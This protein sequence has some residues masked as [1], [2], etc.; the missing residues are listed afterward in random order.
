MTQPDTPISAAVNLLATNPAHGCTAP[1]C[2]TQATVTLDPHLGRRCSKHTPM[3]AGRYRPDLAGDMVDAG[4]AHAAFRYLR[5]WLQRET[6]LRF[7]RVML[8]LA[9]C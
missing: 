8:R 5:R 2:G 1:G 3:P 6:D 4:D 7:V 9:A